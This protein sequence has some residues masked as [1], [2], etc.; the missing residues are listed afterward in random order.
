MRF[1][2]HSAGLRRTALC[3]ALL[4]VSNTNGQQPK[5]P[6]RVMT[7]SNS[8]VELQISP[9]DNRPSPL[10]PDQA[11]DFDLILRNDGKQAITVNSLEGNLDTP[12]I[13]MSGPQGLIGEFTRRLRKEKMVG[14]GS[15][16]RQQSP[17]LE[18]L[19]PGETDDTWVNLLAFHAPLPPG[20]YSF[21]VLHVVDAS[22]RKVT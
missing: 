12:V 19:E 22:G 5:L 16:V 6:R 15:T 18:T 13:R 4:W 9:R 2:A 8:P 17:S 7:P 1:N 21:D 3:A 14:H 20:A 10:Y 11:A